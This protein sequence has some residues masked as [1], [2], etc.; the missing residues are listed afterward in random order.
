MRDFSVII[1]V[2]NCEDYIKESVYSVL[3]QT[4]TDFD[5]FIVDDG[6]TDNTAAVCDK[7]AKADTRIKVIHKANGGQQ[8]ARNAGIEASDSRFIVFLDADDY[9]DTHT[10]CIMKKDMEGVD[11]ACYAMNC[12]KS[13]GQWEISENGIGGDKKYYGADFD[14]IVD[15]ILWAHD[16]S[17]V[18]GV[19]LLKNSACA[20]CYRTD[21]VKEMYRGT[22]IRIKVEE[23]FIFTFSYLLQCSSV[24]VSRKPVYYYRYNDNSIDRNFHLDFLGERV[25]YYKFLNS[26]I[27]KHPRYES[28]KEQL[29]I[30]TFYTTLNGMYTYMGINHPLPK[31][32]LPKLNWKEENF[33]I[34]G[35]G[36]MGRDVVQQLDAVNI[37]PQA[38]IDVKAEGNLYG[39][40]ISSLDK[41][42]EIECDFIYIAVADEKRAYEIRSN[43]HQLGIDDKKIYWEEPIPYT[44]Y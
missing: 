5:L 31:Y 37:H 29:S 9:L 8:S 34:Y 27:K 33:V 2:Y 25:V 20:K 32:K 15:N 42:Q 13:D 21:L 38:I 36:N 23:D 14:F 19:A 18:P 39:V 26:L 11:Y 17:V 1:P 3:N 24:Y 16:E 35:A 4:Y 22:D 10:L 28:L 12:Q 40:S 41:L 30:R 7:L 44:Y 6:S 43:L